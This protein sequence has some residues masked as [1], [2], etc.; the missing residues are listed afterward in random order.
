M[1]VSNRA[2]IRQRTVLD[3]TLHQLR[4]VMVYAATISFF[5]NLLILPMSL[6]S[7]QVYDRVMSTGSLSTL[8]WLTVIMVL[9]FAAAGVLQSL[10]SMVMSRAA[11]WL[12]TT[13]AS[14]AIPISL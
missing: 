7:L 1:S 13:I 6:Y 9:V 2:Q 10:R 8:I 4:P 14:A 12:H 3:I 5:I 11:E